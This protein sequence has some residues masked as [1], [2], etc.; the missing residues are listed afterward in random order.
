MGP[1][2]GVVEGA[3]DVLVAFSKVEQRDRVAPRPVVAA[4]D[5]VGGAACQHQGGV[6]NL[7]D[8][9]RVSQIAALGIP[10]LGG[11]LGDLPAAARLR[12]SGL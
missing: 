12:Q 10:Q 1:H 4:P 11:D 9:S 5:H 2:R 6:A 7:E 8:P 3:G